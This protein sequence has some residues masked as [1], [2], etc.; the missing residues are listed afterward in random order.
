M[1]IDLVYLWADCNDPSWL[2]RKRAFCGGKRDETSETDCKARWVHSDEL[3]YSLRSAEKFVPWIRRIF[4]VTDGQTPHWLDPSN[5]RVTIVDQNDIMPPEARPCF[6]SATIEYFIHN[7]PGLAEHFLYANDDMFFNAHVQPGFFFAPDG[8][9]I[10][11]LKPKPFGKCRLMFK[12]ALGVDIGYYRRSV[13]SAAK[14][15]ERVTGR[16][17]FAV[18]HHGIDAYLRSDNRRVAEEIFADNVADMIRHHVRTEGDIQRVALSFWPLAK[19]RAHL[20]K[21]IGHRE[22][23][24]L[25][26]HKSDW[27]EMMERYSPRLFCLNDGQ[28]ATDDDRARI[29]PFL[30]TLFPERSAFEVD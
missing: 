7:I 19:G 17:Y 6:N 1:E 8:Y 9:P 3:R 27:E 29:R 26:V 4:I 25:M 15:V 23:T 10:V 28:H 11:R 20:R 18:P 16:S 5:P 2:E 22:S 13:V 30:E 21:I 14:E 12:K 24:C